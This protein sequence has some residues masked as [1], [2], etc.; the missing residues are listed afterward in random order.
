MKKRELYTE[1]NSIIKSYEQ[2][3]CGFLD[4][5][6]ILNYNLPFL[7]LDNSS[8][9]IMTNLQRHFK[10][11]NKGKYIEHGLFFGRHLQPEH[12][13]FSNSVVI[14]ISDTRANFLK[15]QAFLTPLAVGPYIQY[16]NSSLSDDKKRQLKERYGKTLLYFPPHSAKIYD[17][18]FSG[19]KVVQE[20]MESYDTSFACIYYRDLKNRDLIRKL[21]KL[22]FIIICAGH[23]YN[24]NF[25]NNLRSIIELADY[26]CS[27]SVG[28]HIPYCLILKKTHL[29]TNRSV[30]EELANQI[31]RSNWPFPESMTLSTLEDRLLVE[32]TFLSEKNISELS[33]KEHSVL[34]TNI[35]LGEDELEIY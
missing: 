21:T 12:A 30:E 7:P 33:V 16:A 26:T 22:G 24:Q 20:L 8:Y 14:T 17:P 2:S 28:T 10:I 29:I 19:F 6:D 18:V 3:D 32:E 35:I 15:D 25:L 9:G 34:G 4:L 5:K 23:R 11:T 27:S 1:R 13:L 31:K